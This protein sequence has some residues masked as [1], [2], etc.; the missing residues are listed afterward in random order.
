GVIAPVV[1]V[2]AS[3]ASAEAIKLIAGAG[4]RNAGLI[5][6][7][8]W[9]NT[10]ESFAVARRDD[11]PVCGHGKFEHLEGEH[12]GAMTAFLCGRDAVQ[13]NP[14]RG[15]TLDLAALAARLDGLGR[16][17]LNEY[18]LRLSVDPYELTI[19]PDARAIVKGTDDS[20]VARSVYARYVGV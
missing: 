18:L 9:D 11:C 10:F 7:D 6:V 1:N 19:F 2:I 12:A 15:H 3:I 14:G 5:N 13:V 8:L 20:T 4:A 17:S 16:I